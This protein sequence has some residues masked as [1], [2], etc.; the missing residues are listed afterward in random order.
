MAAADAAGTLPISPQQ[1][2]FRR[3]LLGFDLYSQLMTDPGG[4]P[5]PVF[6]SWGPGMQEL[7]ECSRPRGL[8]PS[9]SL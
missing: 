9:G 7:A 4:I 1:S 8:G 5:L 6:F 3:T 2:W